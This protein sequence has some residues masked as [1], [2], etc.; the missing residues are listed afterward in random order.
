MKKCLEKLKKIDPSITGKEILNVLH[1]TNVVVCI[2]REI[3]RKRV[4]EKFQQIKSYSN[5]CPLCEGEGEWE[6]NQTCVTD[7]CP[8]C[9]GKGSV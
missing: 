1:L 7:T 3:Q 2:N 8:C 5:T 9:N 4:N 6:N